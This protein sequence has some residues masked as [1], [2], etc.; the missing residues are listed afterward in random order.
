[1][2]PANSRGTLHMKYLQ[3]IAI[4]L[5]DVN[6]NEIILNS[7]SKQEIIDVITRAIERK[8]EPEPAKK[9]T[10][11]NDKKSIESTMAI[12][13]GTPV[14]KGLIV[15]VSSCATGVAHTYMA[16]EALEKHKADVGYDV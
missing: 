13:H 7:N 8:D 16:R 15:G 12:P 14:T 11:G 6:F 2:I 3:N 1:M 4:A 5:L 10:S 9:T